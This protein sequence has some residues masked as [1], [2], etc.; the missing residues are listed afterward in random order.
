MSAAE[1]GTEQYIVSA[2]Q[3]TYQGYCATTYAEWGNGISQS[4]G[5]NIGD[6]PMMACDP[7]LPSTFGT[8]NAAGT[9]Q[10]S[11]CPSKN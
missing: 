3:S 1:R 6:V 4:W 9:V 8:T 2:Q 7:A 5:R 11:V 10:C